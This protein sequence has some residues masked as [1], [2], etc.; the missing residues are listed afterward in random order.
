VLVL[1]TRDSLLLTGIICLVA[2]LFSLMESAVLFLLLDLGAGDILLVSAFI[3]LGVADVGAH[4]GG[5]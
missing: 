5:S 1:L 4:F 3:D 2:V